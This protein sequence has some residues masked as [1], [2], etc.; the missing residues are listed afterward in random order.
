[1][2][3]GSVIYLGLV[4][5]FVAAWIGLVLAPARQLGDLPG[6]VDPV[7]GQTHPRRYTAL[8]LEGRAVYRAEG[9]IYCHSQQIRGGR[10]NADIERGW[11]PRRSHP[12]DYLRDNPVFL[13]TSRTGPD[14]INIGA[15]QPSDSWHHLHLYDPRIV[16]PGSIMPP[17]GY[18][19]ELR[20]IGDQP[21]PDALTLRGGHAPPEGMEVV[22]TRRAR[23]LVA[24]LLSL[25]RTYD[26]PGFDGGR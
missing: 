7:T 15:R 23:A 10:F 20:P 17:F 16:S 3:R 24:Y 9:C 25:D 13:G 26:I 6:A 14:L 5:T 8:E 11:G 19:Y 12:I 2:N 1:M 4:V 18:L 21:S 22:P